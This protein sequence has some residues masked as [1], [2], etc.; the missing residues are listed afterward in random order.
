MGELDVQSVDLEFLDIIESF[1][2]YGLENE[3]PIF[4]VS[5]ANLIKYELIGRDKNHLKLILNSDGYLFETIKF[6]EKF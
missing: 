3:R 6:N 5:N 4:K 2:P 1:E